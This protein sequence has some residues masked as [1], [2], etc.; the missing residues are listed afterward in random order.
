MTTKHETLNLGSMEIVSGAVRV[1]D[2]CYDTDTWCSGEI[3]NVK[4]GNWDCKVIR[5]DEEDWG[6][7]CGYL[8]VSHR[9]AYSLS[10]DDLRWEEQEITVGVDSGQAGIF[11]KKYF[12]DDNNVENVKRH[13]PDNA[14][15]TDEPW[16]SICCDRTLRKESAGTIPNGCV[17]SSGFGD[18]SYTCSIIKDVKEEEVVGIM[19]DFG[20]DES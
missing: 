12:R 5:F 16:Y 4:N 19:I 10:L 3:K 14:I 8:I 7:R 2:P 9:T 6:I 1:S 15:C 11:D 18:G 20:L 17:S 13:V